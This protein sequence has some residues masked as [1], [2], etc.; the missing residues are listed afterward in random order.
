MTINRINSRSKNK[1][2]RYFLSLPYVLFQ[3]NYNR[4]GHGL[5]YAH[6]K[7]VAFSLVAEPKYNE[8][9]FIPPFPNVFLNHLHVCM[10]RGQTGMTVE[11]MLKQ[12]VH[13]F[14]LSGF[15]EK[16][17]VIIMLSRLIVGKLQ[18]MGRKNP[19]KS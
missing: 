12:V 10:P 9:V 14:W 3:V 15:Y 2:G 17:S 13:S 19:F 8:R 1:S 7:K 16:E 4:N 6:T 18:K 5:F 11:E